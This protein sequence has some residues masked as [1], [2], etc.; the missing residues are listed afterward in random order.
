MS[1]AM[2]LEQSDR[3]VLGGFVLSDAITHASVLTP[4]NV[5]SKQLKIKVN[6]SG[7][8]AIFDAP[9]F[10]APTGQF[11]SATAS[12]PVGQSEVTVQDPSLRYLPRRAQVQAPQTPAVGNPQVTFAGPQSIALYPS[13]SAGVELN[14]AAVRATVLGSAGNGLPWAV[15]RVLNS[16]NTA[17]ATGVTDAR[18]EALLAVP[19]LGVQ[20]SAGAGGAVTETTI[21]VTVEA[22]FDPSVLSQPPGWIPDPDDTLGKLGT[23]ALK[24]GQMT[25]ALGAAQVLFAGITIT[26]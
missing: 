17:V 13:P 25:G 8:Y 24:T 4:L 23:A 15:V 20:V 11:L 16:T 2:F 1:S 9:T 12:W 26:F 10:S 18:G 3:R 7:V 21:P 6:R 19:G 5:T 22:W 14:W